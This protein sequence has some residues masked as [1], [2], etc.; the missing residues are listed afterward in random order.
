MELQE[1][2]S[3]LNFMNLFA[4]WSVGDDVNIVI[5]IISCHLQSSLHNEPAWPALFMRHSAALAQASP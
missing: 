2:R 5:L 4:G 3:S 1:V